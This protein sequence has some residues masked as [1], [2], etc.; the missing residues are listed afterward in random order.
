MWE[1]KA[2]LSEAVLTGKAYVYVYED[3]KSMNRS[4]E[5]VLVKFFGEAKGG[6]TEEEGAGELKLLK[7]RSRYLTDVWS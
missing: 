7:E 6:S 5:D 4:V 2:V 3:G 1:D